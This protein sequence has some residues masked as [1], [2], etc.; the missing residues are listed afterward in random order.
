[1]RR[2]PTALRPLPSD[3]SEKNISL[4][5]LV[6]CSRRMNLLLH[7]T[8]EQ[9]HFPWTRLKTSVTTPLLPANI[10]SMDSTQPAA[11]P[12][13]R[14]TQCL[15]VW[16]RLTG[17]LLNGHWQR[18]IPR[19]WSSRPRLSTWVDNIGN[20]EFLAVDVNQDPAVTDGNHKASVVKNRCDKPSACRVI[21]D[22]KVEPVSRGSCNSLKNAHPRRWEDLWVTCGR[23]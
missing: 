15:A 21:V 19:L 11:G 1:M 5:G 9:S 3:P 22:V 10:R 20:S 7:P 2:Q 12:E 14:C 8:I 17:H 23:C 6:W 13:V 18:A 16:K 4:P